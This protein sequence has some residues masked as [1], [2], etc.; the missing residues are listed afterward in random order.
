MK[1]FCLG[2]CWH[3]GPLSRR[4]LFPEKLS[5]SKSKVPPFC[6][7][8]IPISPCPVPAGFRTD[9]QTISLSFEGPFHCLHPINNRLLQI[10]QSTKRTSFWRPDKK[11]ISVNVF[12]TSAA[13]DIPICP[14]RENAVFAAHSLRFC[15][16]EEAG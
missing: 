16:K 8:Y 2:L 1:C 14:R 6:L 5:E 4:F 9:F 3:C 11:S 7:G 15:H 12:R 13:L 10:M